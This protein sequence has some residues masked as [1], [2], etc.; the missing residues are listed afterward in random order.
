MPATLVMVN[1]W[2]G[3]VLLLTPTGTLPW[4]SPTSPGRRRRLA[5][6]PLWPCPRRRTPQLRWVALATV[7]LALLVVVVVVALAQD[8]FD[9][10]A[11]AG[12]LCLLILPVAVG[13][14]SCAIGCTTW[15]HHQPHPDL[16]AAHDPARPRLCRSGAR[17]RPAA[18][19]ELQPGRGRY[20][21]ARTIRGFS[22][23]LRQ[24]LDL[25]TLTTRRHRR[26]SSRSAGASR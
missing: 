25:D 22:A 19:P 20:D 11:L 14:A 8:A 16:R 9:L 24:Q 2:L 4:P 15:M 7:V 3:F 10:A 6:G 23:R 13:A 12:S 26:W 17:A 1:I 18:A 5:G 21:A